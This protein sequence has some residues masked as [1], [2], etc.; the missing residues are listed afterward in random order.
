MVGTIRFVGPTHFSTGFWV[1]VELLP[2]CGGS[3]KNN[4]TVKG[5]FYFECP[6]NRGL[7]VRPSQLVLDQT[8]GR[9]EDIARYASE[10]ATATS[11]A[12]HFSPQRRLQLAGLLKL[13]ISH[14]MGLLSRQLEMAEELEQQVQ[15]VEG[16]NSQIS[17]ARE[18][19]RAAEQQQGYEDASLVEELNL[20]VQQEQKIHEMFH[21]N[22]KSL[23]S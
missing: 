12:L 16:A 5:T 1:G 19:R 8:T 14:V 2:E 20:M 15:Q 23:T 11:S 17:S 3:G 6:P 10:G 18:S 7:F 9:I 4:G 13:N 21:I 22:L